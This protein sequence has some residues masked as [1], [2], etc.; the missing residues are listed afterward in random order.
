MKFIFH[1][2]NLCFKLRIV[3]SLIIFSIGNLTFLK[4]EGSKDLYP[5]GV[6]G[7]R[8]FLSSMAC[9]SCNFNPFATLGRQFV[10]AK[11]G[12][13]IYMGSSVQGVNNGTIKVYAPNGAYYTSGGSTTIGKIAIVVK[14]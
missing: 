7:N 5:S 9:T 10:Y 6:Q 11:S 8:A 12:E 14:N 1:Q 2:H 4:A 3:L 13:T